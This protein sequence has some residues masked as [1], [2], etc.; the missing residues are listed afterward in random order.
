MLYPVVRQVVPPAVHLVDLPSPRPA[1]V[2]LV[3]L[4]HLILEVLP[5]LVTR[6]PLQ[7]ALHQRVVPPYHRVPA[8]C[9]PTDCE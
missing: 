7:T 5:H 8:E 3:V 4:L 1:L 9:I 2:V 6:D